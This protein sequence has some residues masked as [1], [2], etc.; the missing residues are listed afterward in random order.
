MR[1]STNAR[2]LR[3]AVSA[4]L[5]PSFAAL[6]PQSGDH[7]VGN[8]F[9]LRSLIFSRKLRQV[10]ERGIAQTGWIGQECHAGWDG[11]CEFIGCAQSRAAAAR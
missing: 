2:R 8:E 5:R 1:R 6:L 3:K 9:Q 11:W 4:T 10:L 7:V